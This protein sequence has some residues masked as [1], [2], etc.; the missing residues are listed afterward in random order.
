MADQT[1]TRFELRAAD[2]G[3]ISEIISVCS[4]A[5]QW[6]SPDFDEALFRWKHLDNAFGPSLILVATDSAH[7]DRIVAVRAFMR[8]RFATS[9]GETV[10][11]ARAVDTAT[12]PEA[13]GNGLFT[14]L[15]LA[16]L[17]ELE[18]EG[19][20]F[21]FNTPNAKSLPGYL[22][23]GWSS[24]GKVGFGFSATNPASVARIARSRTA[25]QK[26]SVP[27]P[28]LGID[29]GDALSSGL[30][31]PP[32]SDSDHFRTNHDAATLRWRYA[33]GPIDYRYLPI[34]GG[35]GEGGAIVRLRRRGEIDELVVAEVLGSPEP[36]ATSAALRAAQRDVDAD[37]LIAP[38]GTPR[39]LSLGTAGP[40]LALRSLKSPVSASQFR[41][42]PG[43]IELF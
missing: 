42:V 5:L 1:N 25:S 26:P 30:A 36:S 16:G 32:D 6:S 34:E 4:K 35:P 39:T 24:A 20:G 38:S 21:V 23:M 43:D 31:T 40:T 14:R 28:D 10:P 17:D 3:D 12:L 7:D 19:C 2:D 13:Q 41:W 22:K 15:T 33:S 29:I 11:A 9:R 37:L 18:S 27:T 8:W